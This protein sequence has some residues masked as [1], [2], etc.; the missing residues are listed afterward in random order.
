VLRRLLSVTA[1]LLA[2]PALR[3]A[4]DYKYVRKLKA[5]GVAWSTKK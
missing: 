3:A 4:D 1:L 2:A 5:L